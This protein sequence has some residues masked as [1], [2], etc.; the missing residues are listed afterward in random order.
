MKKLC[1]FDFDG[2]M[3]D[4]LTD[5]AKCF[6]QAFEKLGLETLDF[7]FYKESLG[8]NI[9]EIIGIILKDKNTP[10]NIEKVK[11]TY[12]KIYSLDQ[13]ENTK[14]FP[15]IEKLLTTLQEKNI[16][17][18]INS[19]RK[20][21]SINFFVKKYLP[22]ITFIDIQGHVTTNPSK[23]DPYGINKIIEKS[24][25]NPEETVYIGDSITDIKTAENAK[26]D[27]V[28]VKWGYGMSETYKNEYPLKIVCKTSEILDIINN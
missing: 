8:G 16:I 18:A 19:N 2:T 13:K 20:P 6:N 28:I 14:P 22:N 3:F 26:I 27:C 24:G 1:I 17:L 11:K 21:D 15:D 7:Q 23:P 10:E 4:T 5:V 12:E 9:D 25:V